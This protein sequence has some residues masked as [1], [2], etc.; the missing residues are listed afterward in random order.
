MAIMAQSPDILGERHSG[1]DVRTQ[2]VMA[3]RAVANIVKSSLGPVGLD[4]Q[5]ATGEYVDEKATWAFPSS[6]T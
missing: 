6:F 4:K 3:C 1:Q 2:N 5:K